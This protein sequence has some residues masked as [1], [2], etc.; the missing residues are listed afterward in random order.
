MPR[1]AII[2][3]GLI[4]A[5]IGL[6]MRE[7][8]AIK[9]LEIA[10]SDSSSGHLKSA[11]K[12][13]AIDTAMRSPREAVENASLV[14]LATPILSMRRLMTEIA[15]ALMSGAIVT[16]TGSTKAEIMT[17]AKSELPRTVSFIGGHPMAGK[18]ESGPAFA[19]ASLFEDASWAIVPTANA[20]EGSLKTIRDLVET[21]GAKPMFMDAEEHDAYVAAISH[22]PLMLSTALFAMVHESE[23]WPELSQLAAGGFKDTTRLTGTEPNVAFDIAI[24]NRAQIVHWLERYREALRELQDRLSDTDGEEEFFRYMAEA[25][26]DYTGYRAGNIGRQEVDQKMGPIPRTEIAN[27]F[28]GEALASKMRDL[29]AASDAR[30]EELER[31]ARLTRRE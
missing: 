20:S 26:W 12:I 19:D 9:D 23:A 17:W 16:D 22:L 27:L 14:V 11:Q 13:G 5:S 31:K 1:I 25:N 8:S 30:L 29:T 4:G 21:M 28:M 6:R 7:R 18:T 3:T 2:G 24:T 10:G 15:P